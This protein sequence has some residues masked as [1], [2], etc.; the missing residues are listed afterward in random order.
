MSDSKNREA[1]RASIIKDLVVVMLGE[2]AI[3]GL[4]STTSDKQ[5]MLLLRDA[6]PIGMSQQMAIDSEGNPVIDPRTQQP[7]FVNVPQLGTLHWCLLEPIRKF[8][9][10]KETAFYRVSDQG[11]K[12][13][14]AFVTTYLE[15]AV[16]L[17]KAFSQAAE[18][19]TRARARAA[20]IELAKEKDVAEVAAKA[21]I[22]KD[23]SRG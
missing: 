6:Y 11:E 19:E 1:N 16:E 22:F 8:Y 7:K 14:E 15:T 23:P 21:S 17:R 18:A 4:L 5:N 10:P 12:S 13:Q 20:G 2:R 3:L 9:F